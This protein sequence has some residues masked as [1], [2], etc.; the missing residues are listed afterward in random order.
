MPRQSE[1]GLTAN[2]A[3]LFKTCWYCNSGRVLA[4]LMVRCR[5]RPVVQP[6]AQA[7]PTARMTRARRMKTPREDGSGGLCGLYR[8]A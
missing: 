5:S 7:R 4:W 8:L 6:V 3:R 2:A 1:A